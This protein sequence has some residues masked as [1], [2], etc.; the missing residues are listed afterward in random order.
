[1]ELKCLFKQNLLGTIEL[2][3][4]FVFLKIDDKVKAVLMK[5]RRGEEIWVF[6]GT[7][8]YNYFPGLWRGH[9]GVV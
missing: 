5:N 9:L 8:Q 6:Q 3:T 7:L 4:W 2:K 1:M